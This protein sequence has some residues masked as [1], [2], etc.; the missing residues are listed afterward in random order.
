ME[1]NVKVIQPDHGLELVAE[2]LGYSKKYPGSHWEEPE[3][4]R[5]KGEL[6]L[7]CG[8]PEAAAKIDFRQAIDIARRQKARSLE[9]RA[10]ISL[11]LLL[12]AQG[13]SEEAH[14][15]LSDIYGWFAEGIETRDLIEARGLL[16]ELALG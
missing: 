5:L 1:A 8:D 12:G 13:K 14:Q 16:E 3:I 15:S 2:V 10:A 9:L 11:S 7:L 4:Y 6:Q